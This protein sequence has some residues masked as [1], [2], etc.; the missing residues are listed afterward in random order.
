MLMNPNGKI[1]FADGSNLKSHSKV[2]WRKLNKT[3]GMINN[4][5]RTILVAKNQAKLLKFINI[6]NLK[7]F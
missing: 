4:S 5:E 1:S 6:Q 7:Q 3:Q 2:A